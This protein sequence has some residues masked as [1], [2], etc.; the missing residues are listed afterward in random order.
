MA[1]LSIK[2]IKDIVNFVV[3]NKKIIDS[4]NYY[5]KH[6]LLQKYQMTQ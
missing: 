3:F 1:I 6:Y 4:F 2:N 5:Y